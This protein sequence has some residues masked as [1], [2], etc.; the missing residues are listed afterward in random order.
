MFQLLFGGPMYRVPLLA[1]AFG[2]ILGGCGSSD[3]GG[4]CNVQD[5]I[6]NK[7]KCD[8][9]GCHDATGTSAG[10][11]MKTAGW[12]QALVGGMQKA[13]GGGVTPFMSVPACAN[14]PYLVPGSNP[15][16]G[17]FL[18]KM[19]ANFGCGMRMPYTG[20]PVSDADFACFQTWA[21]GLTGGSNGGG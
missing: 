20:S 21:N 19:T 17:L 8:A 6:S 2:V 1:I 7:Y 10:F 3:G 14:M 15:A 9:A 11:S 5:L 12:E 4:A 13:G 18:K 16:T